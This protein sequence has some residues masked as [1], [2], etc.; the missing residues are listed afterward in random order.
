MR[1]D[2]EADVFLQLLKR[3]DGKRRIQTRGLPKDARC[4]GIKVDRIF[5]TVSM[6]LES[7]EWPDVPAEYEASAL[8]VNFAEWFGDA[9]PEEAL[10]PATV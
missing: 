7:D 5:N 10:Q 2:I 4:V 3:L 1:L 8:D 9:M 6:L